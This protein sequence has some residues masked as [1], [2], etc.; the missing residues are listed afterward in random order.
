MTSTVRNTRSL[1]VVFSALV[2]ISLMVILTAA[3]SASSHSAKWSGVGQVLYAGPSI[4][5]ST[6]TATHSEFKIRRDGTV[7]AVEIHTTNELFAGVLSDGA[8]GSAITKCKDRKDSNACERL[9]ALVTGAMVTSLHNSET[10]L[11]KITEETIQ[12]PVATPGGEVV[13]NVPTLSGNIRGKI[14][15]RFAL[16]ND[17]GIAIGTSSLRVRK[18]ST[19]TY[20]CFTQTAAGPVPLESLQ[21][22]IDNT[23]GMLFPIVLDVNDRGKFELSHFQGSLAE[24]LNIEG[25]VEVNAQ[26]NLLLNQFGGLIVIPRAKAT[27]AEEEDV[28]TESEV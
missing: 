13:L 28:E 5:P 22:C 16:S 4:D 6:P 8:G 2:A 12:V 7:R 9:D 27:L 21:P 15:G 14:E 25:K 26:A 24:I 18:G 11:N 17:D 20:A 19:A 23:G 3:A 1:R 10:K